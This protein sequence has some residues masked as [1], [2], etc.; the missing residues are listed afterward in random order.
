MINMMKDVKKVD[1]RAGAQ[2]ERSATVDLG[3]RSAEQTA[4]WC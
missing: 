1:N 3:P 2:H 4:L